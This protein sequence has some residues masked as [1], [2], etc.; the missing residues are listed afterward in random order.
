[1]SDDETAKADEVKE[2]HVQMDVET[3]EALGEL[4]GPCTVWARAT[5]APDPSPGDVV[6]LAIRILHGQV[7]ART[8]DMLAEAGEAAPT[9]Q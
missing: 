6:G 3:L 5:G 4:M 7:C 9:V 2:V 8:S 1:M